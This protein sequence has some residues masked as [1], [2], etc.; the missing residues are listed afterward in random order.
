MRSAGSGAGNCAAVKIKQFSADRTRHLPR[1]KIG[2]ILT[3]LT[4]LAIGA[5]VMLDHRGATVTAIALVAAA[6]D[7]RFAAVVAN[8]LIADLLRIL[9]ITLGL[10]PRAPDVGT[11]R[12]AKT[13]L[14]RA[15]KF[16]AAAC[17]DI[18][19]LPL[20]AGWRHDAIVTDI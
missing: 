11:A 1:R 13:S 5:D 14:P 12:E 9:H 2:D 8:M 17:A 19:P 16:D 10:E 18:I 7:I 4:H 20:D 6:R 15:G 3:V